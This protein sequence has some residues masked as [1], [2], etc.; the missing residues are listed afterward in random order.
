MEGLGI[1]AIR[2]VVLGH[3]SR[4][5]GESQK[6]PAIGGL[7][8]FDGDCNERFAEWPRF[9]DTLAIRIH[10]QIITNKIENKFVDIVINGFDA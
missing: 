9:V 10:R 7:T 4:C 3:R 6:K 2:K 1:P 5:G 8:D